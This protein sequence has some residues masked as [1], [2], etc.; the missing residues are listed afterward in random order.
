MTD[1]HTK[2]A[3]ILIDVQNEYVSGNLPIEYPDIQTSLANIGKAVAVAQSAGIP[4]VLVRQMA[5]ESSPIFAKGS[6]GWQFHP[7]V[8]GITPD[9]YVEKAL[10][11]AL[12][13]TQLGPWL[14]ENGIETLVVAGYMTHN[15]NDSTVRQAVHEGWKV[16]YLH[17]ATGSLPYSN[18]AGSV[19]AKEIHTAFCVVMQSR[20]AA[21]MSTADWAEAV[22]SGKAPLRD[23]IFQSNQR[24]RGLL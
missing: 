3:L 15:C 18:Q 19:S 1:F 21:V 10:P 6:D 23:S 16:E 5:P 24:A 9:F 13:G 2:R 20:F 14:K 22:A 17:D 7:V 11:S 4:I 8:A 12:A